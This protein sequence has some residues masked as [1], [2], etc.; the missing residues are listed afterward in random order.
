VITTYPLA[1]FQH[2]WLRWQRHLSINLLLSLICRGSTTNSWVSRKIVPS[3]IIINL[4]DAVFFP[5][6][7][8]GGWI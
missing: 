8:V 5:S 2:G 4:D 1:F 6:A 7:A 3:S